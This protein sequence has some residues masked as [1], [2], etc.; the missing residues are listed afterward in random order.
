MVDKTV[1]L[2]TGS[3][4]TYNLEGIPHAINPVPE[5]TF[6]REEVKTIMM[7]P[8]AIMPPLFSGASGG[9]SVQSSARTKAL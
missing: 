2:Y 3:K 9:T 7:D 1:A 4:S 5:N 8:L 6:V